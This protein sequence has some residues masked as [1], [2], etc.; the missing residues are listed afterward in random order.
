MWPVL[1]MYGH[2]HFYKA[3]VNICTSARVPVGCLSNW[4]HYNL[5]IQ[6]TLI[7]LS[8]LEKL[9]LKFSVGYIRLGT[10]LARHMNVVHAS[11]STQRGEEGLE[12]R[13][14]RSP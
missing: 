1:T 2:S 7:T 5:N 4:T 10:R 6:I 3:S 12:F 9:S 11:I 8:K 13:L 14:Q